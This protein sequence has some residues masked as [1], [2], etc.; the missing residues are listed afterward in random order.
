MGKLTI[1]KGD[2][3][4]DDIL[5]GHDIIINP[6]NPRMVCGAGVSGAIF[7]KAGVDKLE[8]YTQT[9]YNISYFTEDNP[10][11]VGETR[12]TPGFD[13]GIDIMF[14]QGPKSYEY[15]F[16]EAKRLLMQTYNNI[17]ETAY[18]NG[19][20]KILCP[21]IGTGEY[22]FEHQDIAKD[23]VEVITEQIKNK[24]IDIDIDLVL[25]TEEAKSYYDPYIKE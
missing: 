8:K 21:S 24:N 10:M 2:I 9:K 5:K 17:I 15:E 14:V 22:C 18:V 19:Y 3:T 7:H 12:I 20:K 16:T 4:S 11:K 1:L 23:V 25:Y 13:L 6:T